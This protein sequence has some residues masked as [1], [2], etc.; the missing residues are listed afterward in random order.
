MVYCGQIVADAQGESGLH[1]A[2]VLRQ[3]ASKLELSIGLM[4]NDWRLAQ[5]GRWRDGG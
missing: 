2:A 4:T 5:I 3:L 1:Y